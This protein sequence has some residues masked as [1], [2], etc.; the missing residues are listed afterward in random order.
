[1]AAIQM[2]RHPVISKRA[3]GVLICKPGKDDI[4]KLKAFR[5]ISPHSRLGT[6]V[7]IVAAELLPD[8]AERYGLLSD[9]QFGSRKGQSAIDAVAIIVNRAHGAWT[10]GYI[11]GVLLM[12]IQAAYLSVATGRVVHL[13]KV[14]QMD[15]DHI[16][17]TERFAWERSEELIIKGN[18]MERHP[19]E[20][21]VLQGS[22]VS[23]VLFGI[24]TPPL[25]Q[26][27][28][29]YVSDAKMLSFV[30]NRRCLATTS[31]VNHVVSIRE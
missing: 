29:E 5:S 13:I 12:D 23:P 21:G 11:S 22:P 28:E 16:R 20:A 3:R 25:M 31:D 7:D 10:Y 19:V 2:G 15:G 17:W 8:D 27:V 14:R 18:A 30:H 24:Y 6:V 1:M 9:G 26:W 4:A